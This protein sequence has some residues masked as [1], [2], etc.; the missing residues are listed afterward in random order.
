MNEKLISIY[1]YLYKTAGCSKEELKDLINV[2]SIKTVE[3]TIRK[4]EDII[5]DINLRKYRFVNLLPK[6][7]PYEIYLN[8]MKDVISNNIIKDDFLIFEKAIIKDLNK[9]MILT[10]NLS[11]LS[12]K[13]IQLKN[14][15]KYNCQL[16]VE[17][18][19][20]GKKIQKKFIKPH[21]VFSSNSSF[22]IYITYD[23]L[24]N[25]N[26]GEERTFALNS[27]GNIKLLN[28]LENESL[29]S[30]QEGN[31]FGPFKKDKFIT[32]E[33]DRISG[34]FF[35]REILFQNKGYDLISEELDGD[36]L[37][38][39]MYYNELIEIESV[40]QKWMPRIKIHGNN[41]I[42]ETVYTNIRT[43]YKTLFNRED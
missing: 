1:T 43:N 37:I 38:V 8:M 14:A 34:D 3:S 18:K 12:K 13:I 41:S 2:S 9:E 31:A 6:Y 22:Y 35:K 39:K 4:I 33:L 19:G 25:K 21:K 32:L 27:I 42:K 26:I 30:H 20:N 23:K 40:I 17:Y 28:F 5:Y 24:N 15:I 10:E 16:E 29:Y 11:N 7:I 36:I